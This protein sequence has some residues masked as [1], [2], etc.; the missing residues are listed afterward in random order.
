VSTKLAPDIRPA[1]PARSPRG[2]TTIRRRLPVLV[3]GVVSLLA[4]L[5]GGL[6][7]LG[8]SVPTLHGS[9]AADHGPLMALGFLG[10]VISLERAVALR[11]PWAF[12]APAAAGVGGL[13]LI[14]GLPATLGWSLL[15]LASVVLIVVYA[16]V[17]RIQPAIHLSVM[18]V[19]AV[20]WYVATVLWLGGWTVP[21]IV[22][23]LAGF[24][25]LTVL[26]ER[27]ELARVAIL[28]PTSIRNFV[29]AAGTF[30]AGLV[31]GSATGRLAE[32]GTRL[33]G[34]GL[35]ALALW[36]AKYDVA[37]RTV[38]I[39]GVTRFMAVCLLS[40]YVWLVVG[41]LTWLVAGDPGRTVGTYDVALHAVFL[42]FVMSMI[43][44]HAPVIVPAV[45]SVRLPFKPWFYAHVGLLHAA[46]FVRL[47]L[48]DG[49]GNTLAWQIG[50]VGTELAI[51]MFL[52]ASAT[53]V[54]RA[55]R[56]RRPVRAS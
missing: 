10:T 5:W 16:V 39:A 2:T 47:A 19:G 15:C 54:V 1:A 36:G 24:L 23:W 34:V 17:H 33:A 53:A 14:A 50:G 51:I 46:L 35:I 40:G 22:P 45:L 7:L 29:A 44:G 3:L 38:K 55:Q 49:L 52:A 11:R 56:H 41:G 13:A 4:G 43:F 8:L 20:C 42:G 21:R 48:G 31:L 28:T 12:L 6:L 25:V 9:T 26:G 37:R 27:L 18:A 30:T 32:I